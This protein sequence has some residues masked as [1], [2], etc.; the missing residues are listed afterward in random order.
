MS[1]H[2]SLRGADN[3]V[4]DRSVLS[5]GERIAQL[6]KEGKFDPQKGSIYGLPKVRTK[7]KT[8]SGKKA[9]ALE[10][11]SPGKAPADDKKGADAKKGGGDKKAK[12]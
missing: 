8:V 7:F 6:Q 12:K 4:G 11:A 1:I 2:S 3:L 5:R 10:A 9:K